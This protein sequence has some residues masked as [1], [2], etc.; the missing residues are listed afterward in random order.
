[1]SVY[2]YNCA[3]VYICICV[4]VYL[5]ICVSVCIYICLFVYLY[6][7]ISLYLCI[8]ISTYLCICMYLYLCVC[9]TL[10]LCICISLYLCPAVCVSPQSLGHPSRPPPRLLPSGIPLS[11]HQRFFQ[12]KCHRTRVYQIYRYI[13]S[14]LT[15]INMEIDKYIS[16]F[17]HSGIPLSFHR[18]FFPAQMSPGP[19]SGLSELDNLNYRGGEFSA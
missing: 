16:Q 10:Y 8:C 3:S 18:R 6:I 9:I 12:H 7:C 4:S 15:N 2:N 13:S 17:L 19:E 5:C 1:M 14:L 11:F